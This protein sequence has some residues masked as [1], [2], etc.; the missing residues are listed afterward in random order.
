MSRL[1]R[2]FE[3]A[4]R[5]DRGALIAYV[6]AGDP[7]LE[8]SEAYAIACERGGADMLELGVPFSDP[9]A[10]GPEIQGAAQRALAA[11][12][13]PGRA[14]DLARKI[15]RVSEV[16]IVLMGYYNPI[17]SMGDAVFAERAARAGADGLIVPD[18]PP[19][20]ADPLREGCRNH[21]LD[22]VF[23]V[24]PATD[25]KRARMIAESSSGF[26]Y[27]VSRYGITGVSRHLPAGLADRIAEMR[28]ASRLPVAVGFGIS[29]AESV[30][31]VVRAG[32]HAAVV[33]SAIV[34]R[35]ADGMPPQGVESF[36]RD[37]ATGL[38]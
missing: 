18:L 8:A 6:M 16:P 7:S 11:G 15:R 33:G 36:L 32:A 13:T 27:L 26:V 38:R 24:S 25:G 37:L 12:T 4:R 17:F 3:T 35:I 29:S 21:G 1:A 22:F 34:K 30:R 9:V 28:K 5:E 14:F 31:S 19:E 23:L 20:E 10:D 2:A